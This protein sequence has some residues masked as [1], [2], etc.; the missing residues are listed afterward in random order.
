[1]QIVGMLITDTYITFSLVA[2]DK[3]GLSIQAYQ[4]NVV[5]HFAVY[6]LYIYNPTAIRMLIKNFMY[7]YKLDE[8]CVVIAFESTAL[9]EYWDVGPAPAQRGSHVQEQ[10]LFGKTYGAYVRHEQ[11]LSYKLLAFNC[12]NLLGITTLTTALYYAHS[13]EKP[14]TSPGLEFKCLEDVK[15]YLTSGSS[16]LTQT[17][18]GIYTIGKLLY[19]AA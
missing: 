14:A 7:T 18:M 10:S 12:F 3:N 9:Q 13:F 4:E 16:Q 5:E 11:L 15:Q 2:E 17:C 8:A 19:E 6:Q 1:M